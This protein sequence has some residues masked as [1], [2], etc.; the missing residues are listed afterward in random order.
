LKRFQRFQFID[1]LM[2]AK[3]FII[4]AQNRHTLVYNKSAINDASTL[5]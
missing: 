4:N 3:S 2:L 1:Y 5:P